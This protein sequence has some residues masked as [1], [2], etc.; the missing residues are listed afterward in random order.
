MVQPMD[1]RSASLS[2]SRSAPSVGEIRDPDTSS[3]DLLSL[4][5]I[6][7][8]RALLVAAAAAGVTFVAAGVLGGIRSHLALPTAAL[9]LA[10]LV[11]AAGA[12]GV[13]AA[14]YAAAL[15]AALGFAVFLTVPY[16]SLRIENSED[17]EVTLVLSILGAIATEITQW[18]RRQQARA[19]RAAGYLDGL[20]QATETASLNS[21]PSWHRSLLLQQIASILGAE[22]AAVLPGPCPPG[23]DTA[24]LHRDGS[25]SV[26]AHSLALDDGLPTDRE[27]NVA[28][29]G[30]PPAYLE[31]VAAAR[32]ARPT[33]E[34]RR[35]ALA[36]ADQLPR[37]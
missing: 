24:I 18:G 13:R 33:L 15:A 9:I 22:T 19:S 8:E 27:V 36:L 2:G 10:T 26:G 32:Q 6:L 4:Y 20:L 3:R 21:P 11:V 28:L 25:I 16:G 1:P 5:S 31:I 29:P 37:A 12:T 14:G 30:H 35:L 17:V 7:R 34:Q 23:A